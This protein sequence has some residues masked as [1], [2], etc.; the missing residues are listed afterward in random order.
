LLEKQVLK[1]QK[2]LDQE[3]ANQEEVS[4]GT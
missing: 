3:L 2:R 1:A 4:D